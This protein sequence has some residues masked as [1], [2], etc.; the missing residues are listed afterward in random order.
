MHAQ[1]VDFLSGNRSC[2]WHVSEY[3]SLLSH[4]KACISI[5]WQNTFSMRRSTRQISQREIAGGVDQFSCEIPHAL[6]LSVLQWFVQMG[7]LIIIH[8]K[9]IKLK[10]TRWKKRTN[11][12]VSL[13]KEISYYKCEFILLY[14]VLIHLLISFVGS[15]NAIQ[16]FQIL[17]LVTLYPYNITIFVSVNE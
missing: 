14:S 8:T 13:L 11:Q 17:Q 12:W 3:S 1:G 5:I 15:Y 4:L 9:I 10:Q 7:F 16:L 6:Q 2:W